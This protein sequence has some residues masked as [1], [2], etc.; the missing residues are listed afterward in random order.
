MPENLWAEI[1]LGGMRQN[2][3]KRAS[4]A[5]C[6]WGVRVALQGLARLSSSLRLEMR[7]PTLRF[8]SIGD[9]WGTLPLRLACRA[10]LKRPC[11]GGVVRLPHAGSREDVQRWRRH[12]PPLARIISAKLL[13]CA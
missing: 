7:G 13:T 4:N 5:R 8:S 12:R 2:G 1:N 3:S 11:F 6:E 9:A 10:R